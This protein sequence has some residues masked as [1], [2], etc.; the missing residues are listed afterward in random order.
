M[1]PRECGAPCAAVT[2]TRRRSLSRH[3]K[4]STKS[5]VGKGRHER[6]NIASSIQVKGGRRMLLYLIL[7]Y[8][9]DVVFLQM[10]GLW[11]PCLKQAI[12]PTVFAQFMFLLTHLGNP[13]NIPDFL[14]VFAIKCICDQQSL[15]L[16]GQDPPSAKR[17]Q[18][19]ESSG[20]SSHFLTMKHFLIKVCTFLN[21]QCYCTLNRLWGGLNIIFIF[22]EK[23][24]KNCDSLHSGIWTPTCSISKT[25]LFIFTLSHLCIKCEQGDAQR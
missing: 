24:K 19:A 6:V 15:M 21:T 17:L 8:F 1:S 12:F 18:L 11:Q 20:G 9:T 10:Q 16:L 4:I 22:A 2:R 5:M 23:P 14:I 13:H 3:R 7:L 25:H